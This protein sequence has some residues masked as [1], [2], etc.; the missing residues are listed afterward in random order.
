[1][2][3]LKIKVTKEILRQTCNCGNGNALEGQLNSH[4]AIAVAIR[5]VFPEALVEELGIFLNHKEYVAKWHTQNP[6][7]FD[8]K[9]PAKA[10]RFILNFDL[11]DAIE[12]MAMNPIEFEVEI[13][14]WII[15]T[16][17]LEE[18]KPLLENHPTL[19]LV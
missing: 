18:L 8:I 2:T 9:L 11:N 19:E 16:I 5:D 6:D 13:P 7:K 12:R 14:D 10:S 15:E 4:C 17:N 1:M 3:K